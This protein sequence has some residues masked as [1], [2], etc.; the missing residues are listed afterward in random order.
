MCCPTRNYA[1]LLCSFNAVSV[2]STV[3]SVSSA[4]LN[5]LHIYLLSPALNWIGSK[6]IE[7][8]CVL[9]DMSVYPIDVL[10]TLYV[11]VVPDNSKSL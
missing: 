10:L 8:C 9:C 4:P 3:G 11:H 6:G 2:S 1:N 7:V 5:I